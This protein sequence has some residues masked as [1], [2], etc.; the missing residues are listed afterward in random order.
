MVFEAWEDDVLGYILTNQVTQR[1]I[2]DATWQAVIGVIRDVY[3]FTITVTL[4]LMLYSCDIKYSLV[5][6]FLWT[7]STCSWQVCLLLSLNPRI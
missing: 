5:L 1:L 6:A 3:M 2:Q 7:L 4:I